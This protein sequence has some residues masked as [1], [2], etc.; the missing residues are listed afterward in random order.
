MATGK[1]SE[2]TPRDTKFAQ[3]AEPARPVHSVGKLCADGLDGTTREGVTMFQPISSCDWNTNPHLPILEIGGQTLSRRANVPLLQIDPEPMISPHALRRRPAITL[4]SGREISAIHL[5]GIC[6]SGMKSLAELAVGLGWQVSGSDV[7]ATSPALKAMM[8]RGLRIHRGHQDHFLPAEADVLVHSPAVSQANPER[9]MAARLGIPQMSYNQMLGHLMRQ[10]IGLCIA[11]THGKS[12]TTAMT[13]AILSHAGLEPSAI[14]GAELC[15]SPAGSGWAGNGSHFIVES[16]EYQRN[17]LEYRPRFAAITGIEP[18]HFDY[19]QT[20]A[21]TKSA[22]ADFAAL[23]EPAGVLVV[24]HDCQAS[25]EAAA[26]ARCDVATYSRKPGADWWAADIKR[27]EAGLRFRVFYH[28]WYF[29]EISLKVPGLHNVENALVATAVS[30]YAGV[31]PVEIR[32][33]LEHFSGIRRRFE[34]RG[35]WRGITL[36]DDYAHHPTAVET[37]LRT[38]RDCYGSRKIWCVFQP[39]QLT[40]LKA[41]LPEFAA[42]FSQADRV[43]VSPVFAAREVADGESVHAAQDLAARIRDCGTAAEFGPSLDQITATLD[44]NARPGD[45]LITMGAGDVN[46]IHH[47]FHR[48]LQRN[49]AS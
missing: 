13:A 7:Q 10:K 42:A 41:L 3:L 28:G 14:I 17:F 22:F 26:S 5:V 8:K 36:I 11:G 47:E 46:R 37:T 30:H 34:R 48:R 18:D 19:Y 25:R 24:K 9:Q 44:D 38:A 43:L 23:V 21:D 16:C 15:D 6:G 45:V 29:C 32:E 35:S 1:Q 33:S 49:T 12:T 4:P 31:D 39:H 2:K 40:R 27:T 20:F